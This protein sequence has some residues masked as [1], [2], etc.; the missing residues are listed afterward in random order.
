MSLHC[1]ESVQLTEDLW[2][3]E[4]REFVASTAKTTVLWGRRVGT[5]TVGGA[6]SCD[7]CLK[8]PQALGPR[9]LCMSLTTAA[10]FWCC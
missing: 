1:T 3:Y 6:G 2:N 4:T 10:V 8:G 9:Q 7:S 5:K